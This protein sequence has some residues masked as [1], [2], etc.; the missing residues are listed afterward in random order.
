M[1]DATAETKAPSLSDTQGREGA[2]TAVLYRMSMPKHL[3]PYGLKTKAFL[4]KGGYEVEDH[5]LTTRNETDEFMAEAGVKTTPQT[6]IGGDRIGGYE[7]VRKY[8]GQPVREEGSTT[9]QP[10][11]AVFGMAFLMAV[12]L[13][14]GTL[15]PILSARALEVFIAFS[16]CLLALQKL[17]DIESFSTMFLNYDLLAQRWVWYGY[18]YPVAEALAGL[19]MLTALPLLAA[20]IAIFIGGLGAV[21][22]IK[23]VYVDKRELKCACMGGSSEVPLGFVSLTENLMMLFAG[24]WMLF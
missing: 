3:C 17:R 23:A 12:A 20:P 24:I 14:F 4:E 8:L 19:L 10:V 16:M 15:M 1:T 2:K 21:S 11:I 5:L 18:V 6:Y 7:E 13:A 9:Y 22:V